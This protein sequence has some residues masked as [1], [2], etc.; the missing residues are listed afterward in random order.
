MDEIF[1]RFLEKNGPITKRQE[2][3]I[4]HSTLY[5]KTTRAFT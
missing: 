3:P 4:K 5:R 1:S 2:P